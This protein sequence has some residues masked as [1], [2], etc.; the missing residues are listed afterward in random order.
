M[1]WTLSMSRFYI[2]HW[3]YSSENENYYSQPNRAYRQAWE[4]DTEQVNIQS[5]RKVHVSMGNIVKN[6]EEHRSHWKYS[7]G[8]AI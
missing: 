7:Q 6:W 4:M 3:G 1:D 2:K 5:L 8:S